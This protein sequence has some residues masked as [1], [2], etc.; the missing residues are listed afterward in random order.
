MMLT[1]GLMRPRVWGANKQATQD[2]KNKNNPDVNQG[3]SSKFGER[4][5]DIKVEPA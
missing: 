1:P 5:S 4:D 2:A 3:N